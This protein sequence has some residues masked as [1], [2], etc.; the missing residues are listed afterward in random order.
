MRG[1]LVSFGQASVDINAPLKVEL[2]DAGMAHRRIE[3]RISSGSIV[4][5]VR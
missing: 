5:E 3:S 4:L 2:S 1:T